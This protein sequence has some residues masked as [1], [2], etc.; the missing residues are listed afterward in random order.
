MMTPRLRRRQYRYEYAELCSP[1]GLQHI[2]LDCEGTPLVAFFIP[3]LTFSYAHCEWRCTNCNILL[4]TEISR[5][6]ERFARTFG[7]QIRLTVVCK[8]TYATHAV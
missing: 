7:M 1:I 8:R 6:N 4:G 2:R 5:A 3:V